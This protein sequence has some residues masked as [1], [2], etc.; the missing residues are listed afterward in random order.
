MAASQEEGLVVRMALAGSAVPKFLTLIAAV[1]AHL[2]LVVRMI[3]SRWVKEAVQVA[4]A[5]WLAPSSTLQTLPPPHHLTNHLQQND[6]RCPKKK[7][8]TGTNRMV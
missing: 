2:W 3:F 5:Q 6:L 7:N 1:A 4:G 8:G